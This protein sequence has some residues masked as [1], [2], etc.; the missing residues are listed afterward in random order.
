M[1]D[2]M[3]RIDG[4]E[5]QAIAGVHECVYDCGELW[6]REDT[7]TDLLTFDLARRI[8]RNYDRELGN[9]AAEIRDVIEDLEPMVR[10]DSTGRRFFSWRNL[11]ITWK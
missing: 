9:I 7:R 3:F 10:F 1:S 2:T 6:I 4:T 8:V 11:D 5:L